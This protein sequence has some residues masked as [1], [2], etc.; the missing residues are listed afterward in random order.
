MQKTTRISFFVVFIGIFISLLFVL[1]K[2]QVFAAKDCDVTDIACINDQIGSLEKKLKDASKK[3]EVL[4]Q[5]LNQINSS[6]TATQKIIQKTQVLLNEAAQTIKQKEQEIANLEQ[7]LTL[8]KE[9]LK[10]LIRELYA[11]SDIP[12][13]EI[14]LTENNVFG[15]FQ[16]NDNL[17]S[18]Q[19]KMQSVIQD[20]GDMQT[21]VTGEKSSLEEVKKDQ[22]QLLVLKNKQK[23]SLVADQIDTA[24]NIEDQQTIISRLKKELGQ[25]QND[26]NTVL[27]KSYN[28]KDIKDAVDF[29]SKKT[30]V[31]QGFLF[32]VLKMETNLGANVGGCTYAEVEDGA[33]ASY[34]AK[35]LG[36]TAWATFQKRRDLFKS[37]TDELGIDYRKQ[38]VSCNP[39][40]Y[41]G[42]GG[43]M[44]VA[45]FMPDTWMAYK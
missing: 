40:G 10:G 44:G 25:L 8:E 12:L 16:Q 28:A 41:T 1:P 3:Q 34:K 14:L 27:G 23:Q 30:G 29:A 37:I 43:A 9:V 24:G 17:L 39:K 33:Q 35:K 15:L 13:P 20:I 6:L 31:P 32:G 7:Q 4:Q 26:L 18:T 21:K 5:N 2:N 45:Q 38:K 36:K 19:E 22:E 42:T 11:V